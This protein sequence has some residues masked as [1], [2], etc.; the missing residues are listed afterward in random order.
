MKNIIS[1]NY[2]KYFY[3][4][5]FLTNLILFS[6]NDESA[7]HN[8]F[9]EKIAIANS[10]FLILYIFEDLARLTVWKQKENKYVLI[11]EFIIDVISISL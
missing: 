4:A 3:S 1:S 8:D 11:L 2:L 7:Y 5:L 10:V 6:L 9:E